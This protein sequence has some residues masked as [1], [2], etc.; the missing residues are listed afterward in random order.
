MS[1]GFKFAT[2]EN[3]YCPITFAQRLAVYSDLTF[4]YISSLSVTNAPIRK[5]QAF[6]TFDT[7]SMLIL[8]PTIPGTSSEDI[9]QILDGPLFVK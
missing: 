1:I 5:P 8:L 9:F 7:D 4:L 3:I 6:Q 2:D